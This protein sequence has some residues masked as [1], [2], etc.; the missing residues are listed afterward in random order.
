MVIKLIR[1]RWAGDVARISEMRNIY[2]ILVGN[3]KERDHSED[4]YVDRNI[5]T[6]VRAIGLE[7]FN[8]ILL[9]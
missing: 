2:N 7:V 6:D 3:L 4:L 9:V 8:C 1:M 5:R